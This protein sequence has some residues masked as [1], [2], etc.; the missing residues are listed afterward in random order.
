MRHAQSSRHI[1]IRQYQGAN[2]LVCYLSSSGCDSDLEVQRHQSSCM[3]MCLRVGV[4]AV[5]QRQAG[6]RTPLGESSDHMLQAHASSCYT[7]QHNTTQPPFVRRKDRIQVQVATELLQ[8][9][10]YLP[11]YRKMRTE[12]LCHGK[13]RLPCSHSCLY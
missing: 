2:A 10:T 9:S 7:A 11:T 4:F 8:L 5:W 13:W 6:Q 12:R 3:C 1:N